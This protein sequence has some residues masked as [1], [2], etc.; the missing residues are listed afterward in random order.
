MVKK[1]KIDLPKEGKALEDLVEEMSKAGVGFGHRTS[2]L[3]PK[4]APYI[5]GIKSTI[6]IIDL[7][8]TIAEL[9]K[10]LSFIEELFLKNK[11]LLLI[12]TKVQFRELVEEVAK[13]CNLPYVNQ[14]WIGGALTNFS[15]ISQRIKQL[16]KMEEDKQKGN[17]EKYS[18]KNV[19]LWIMNGRNWKKNLEACEQ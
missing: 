5:L 4:M 14:R 2:K 15:V 13:D 6:H 7:E 16:E 1:S 8:K 12:G 11:S 3:H 18:K 9:R 19:F 17:W 10:T